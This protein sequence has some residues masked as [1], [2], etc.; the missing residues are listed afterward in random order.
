[1]IIDKIDLF[2][3]FG[4]ERGGALAGT[5]TCYRHSQYAEMNRTTR[6]PAMLV[7][8]GG[9]YSFVSEREGD[10]VAL[11]FF[12]AG[13]DCFVLDY[14]VAPRFSYPVQVQEAAMA[15]MYIRKNAERL[16]LLPD[17]VA[18]IG[19]SAGGHLLGCISVLWDDPAVRELF[20]EECVSVR[21]DASVYSYA[22]VSSDPKIYHGGSFV[23]F[24][25]TRALPDD[26]SIDKK[27]RPSCKPSFIWANTPDDCVRVENSVRLYQAL[28]AAG[29]PAELHLFR[30]GWHG[31]T[32]CSEEVD[33]NRP[34]APALAYTRSW[35]PLCKKFLATL[36]FVND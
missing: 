24:C 18:A 33:G 36:G 1:M 14:D 2:S 17:K 22:V 26:Y 30:D 28:T 34:L 6:H 19:F 15:M 3:Y 16:L 13:F 27:V 5:L 23:N 25:G 29:V 20:G 12:G 8:P 21:P 31:M 32:V 11:A 10:P 7:I 9:G 4:R 35:L